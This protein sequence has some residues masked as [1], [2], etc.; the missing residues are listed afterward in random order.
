[1]ADW[2][3]EIAAEAK[4]AKKR[5]QHKRS[6]KLAWVAVV[7]GFVLMLVFPVLVALDSPIV[8]GQVSRSLVP[9]VSTIG[10]ISL[11]WGGAYLLFQRAFEK[12]M[13]RNLSALRKSAKEL[14]NN[15]GFIDNDVVKLHRD[16][17]SLTGDVS[18]IDTAMHVSK[19]V[20]GSGLAH[21]YATREDCREKI[22]E[23]LDEAL[24]SIREG[25]RQSKK[26]KKIKVSLLGISLGAFLTRPAPLCKTFQKVLG[27]EAFNIKLAILHDG[28]K[29]ACCRARVEEDSKYNS[30]DPKRKRCWGCKEDQ[31]PCLPIYRKVTRHEELEKSMRYLQSLVPGQPIVPSEWHPPCVMTRNLEARTYKILPMVFMFRMGND[32]F[33]EQYYLGSRGEQPPV[34]HIQQHKNEEDTKKS[35]LF[36]IF[37]EHFDSVFA[38]GEKI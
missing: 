30:W 38:M 15:V 35:Q 37:M 2:R 5:I 24:K 29:A 16:V 4:K 31:E 13:Q 17:R 12:D 33:V 21:I 3:S 32:M 14:H 27:S 6:H 22:Q 26:K 9:L 25:K 8:G 11:G 28:C 36:R 7:G 1:M 10:G 20:V 23:V 19:G 18:E 34:L